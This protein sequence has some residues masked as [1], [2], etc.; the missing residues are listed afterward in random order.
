[1][2]R[3]IDLSGKTFGRLTVV[4]QL[5][6]VYTARGSR[7]RWLCK[8]SCGNE[9][10]VDAYSLRSGHTQS[11]GCL[12]SEIAAKRIAER[13]KTHGQSKSKLFKIWMSMRNRC[14]YPNTRYYKDYGGRGIRVCDE[15][16]NSFESFRKW[17]LQ[18]G[19]DENAPKGQYTI[20]RINVDG[21][22]C[23]ENCKWATTKEQANN[24]RNTLYLTFNG[25][26]QSAAMWADEYGLKH[27]T[28]YERLRK[29]WSI[30]D[31]ITRPTL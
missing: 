21:N 9:L 25:I 29:G 19:Y 12:Q 3:L 17:A 1:M 22:Y 8:C 13:T 23:P 6:T 20:E 2:S 15:W 24:K 4:K 5:P 11:C 7:T 16:E 28:L 27:T 18:T 30:E 31:A 10:E 14:S 26:T